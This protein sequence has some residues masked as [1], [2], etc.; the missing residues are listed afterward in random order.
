MELEVNG[1]IELQVGGETIDIELPPGY[2]T[3]SPENIAKVSA[4]EDARFRIIAVSVTPS[5]V[6]FVTGDGTVRFVK[7]TAPPTIADMGHCVSLDGM[8]LTT[9]R[10]LIIRSTIL[11][12]PQDLVPITYRDEDKIG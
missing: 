2:V 3:L 9:A 6:T 1:V 5:G 10:E 7:T 8:H 4:M 11:S 12:R